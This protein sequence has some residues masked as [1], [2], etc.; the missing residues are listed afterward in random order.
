MKPGSEVSAALIGCDG[1]QQFLPHQLYTKKAVTSL[2]GQH[3][4][5]LA[6]V[7]YCGAS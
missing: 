1:W 6:A 3:S 5:A 7:E 2:A 4:F